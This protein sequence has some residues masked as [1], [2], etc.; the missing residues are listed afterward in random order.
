MKTRLTRSVRVAADLILG[1]KLVA[2][3][4]ETVY[5]LGAD[6]FD[7]DAVSDIFKAK[8]RPGDNPLIVHLH[9]PA[10]LK[11]VAREVPPLARK[12][13]RHFFP[14]PLTLVLK[15]QPA[16]PTLVTAGLD[17]VAVRMPDHPVAR[18]FLAACGCPVAAPSANRS[19][20]P[21][22]TSWQAVQQDLAG[23]I[24]AILQGA[25]TSVGLES[26]VLDVTGKV[27]V[28]LRPGGISLQELRKIVPAT[29]LAGSADQ[30]KGRSPGL[31][32]RHYAPE[33]HVVVVDSPTPPN[34]RGRCAYIGLD[35]APNG[36][37]ALSRTCRDVREYARE[38][39]H[40][41]RECDAAGIQTIACGRAPDHGLGHAVMDRI[42]RAAQR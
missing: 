19:G 36:V 5:G 31:R 25:R 6:A 14:G 7:E 8:G 22:P 20:R 1:G 12:F 16:V 17:T 21:S 11:L 24:D 9:T 26:T 3:P 10:Q 13:I 41:L 4:T 39:F 30:K 34:A 32:H 42:H 15:K 18:R 33:A 27:P 40:F 37:F 2:F 38:L 29:R 23:R 28:V 35:R